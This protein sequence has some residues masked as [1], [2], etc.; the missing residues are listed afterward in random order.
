MR[1][2]TSLRPRAP[3]ICWRRRAGRASRA[4][5]S[6]TPA[7]RG[8]KAASSWPPPTRSCT[9]RSER[10]AAEPARRVALVVG[11]GDA[12]GGAVARRF[13]RGG[14]HVCATR[15]KLDQLQP[16]LEEIRAAGGGGHG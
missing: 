13:A 5:T 16:L 10:M 2:P 6:T 7:R 8:A 1:R 12:T 4:D 15:R 3:D 9:T 14:Y 11:A